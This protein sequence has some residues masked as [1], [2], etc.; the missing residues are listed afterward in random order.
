MNPGILVSVHSIKHQNL[1]PWRQL[2]CS[3]IQC[4]D[5]EVMIIH[6]YSWNWMCLS[7]SWFTRETNVYATSRI[8][9]RV[10]FLFASWSLI[11]TN[12]FDNLRCPMCSRSA[13]ELLT[14]AATSSVSL[15]S[16]YF[17]SCE[18]I[19]YCNSSHPLLIIL[20][21][22]G[23]CEIYR[24]IR[25]LLLPSLISNLILHDK[26]LQFFLILH[27]VFLIVVR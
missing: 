12:L 20:Y 1:K 8:Q 22:I 25:S 14:Q 15:L 19:N 9:G 13:V 10:R 16:G 27:R 4:E 17:R 3:S 2:K 6:P 21:L 23:I 5:G 11:S 18:A 26:T 24:L 7:G